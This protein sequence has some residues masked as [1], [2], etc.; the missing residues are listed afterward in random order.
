VVQFMVKTREFDIIVFGASG[1]TGQLTAD[2]LARQG[3]GKLRWA[4]AGRNIDKLKLLRARLTD[5]NPDCRDLPLVVADTED[6]DSMRRLA[7]S[8]RVV[9]TTV[10]P[11]LK[12]GE[13][14]VA[15][16]AKAGTDYVDLTGEPE[17]VDR[18]WLRYHDQ[19]RSSGARIVNCCGFDSI[20]HD[21][22]AW[23]TVQQLPAGVPLRVE[24]FVR[25]GGQFS[26]GTLHS[27]VGAMSR[28]AESY[29]VSQARKREEGWPVDRRI[30]AIRHGLRYIKALGTWTLPLPTIDPQIVRR[31]AAANDRYGPDFRYGHF[32]QVKK[33]TGVA[34]LVGGVGVAVVGSQFSVTRK[35]LLA[36]RSPGDGPSEATRAKG[37]FKVSFIGHG[38]GRDVRCEVS[39]GDPGY[40]ETAKML[41]ESALCLA[42]DKLPRTA[43]V[44]TPAT[45]MGN[46]LIERLQS[47]GICFR[48]VEARK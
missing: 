8:T 18:M 32:V 46:A 13:P 11:Y 47:A 24:G 35:R 2:Y 26:G 34:Q 31:S 15:A 42:Q 38:G 36:L 10:G 39:G 43:G 40:G 21:L 22:G 3:G 1:F 30:G 23:F 20:P 6:A 28:M 17:F 9:I 48:V 19:A 41:A 37:W 14:L 5:A 29:K 27:A 44:I 33:L 12:Y 16:C 7:E 4:V 25:A 45:A